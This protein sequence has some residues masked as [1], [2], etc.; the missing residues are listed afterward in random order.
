MAHIYLTDETLDKLIAVIGDIDVSGSDYEQALQ[1]GLTSLRDARER[2][3]ADEAFTWFNSRGE[4]KGCAPV[5]FPREAME[6]CAGSGDVS[7]AVHYWREKLEFTV[8]RE[9]A[10]SWLAE[11]GAWD[12]EELESATDETL[13]QRVLWLA[14]CE[15]Q[16]S[17]ENTWLGLI[18]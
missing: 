11:T 14:C 17:S 16:E 9:M 5:G 12:R 1:D 15:M 4:F 8:P 7:D 3:I 6:D 10:I 2:W 13:A 18:R